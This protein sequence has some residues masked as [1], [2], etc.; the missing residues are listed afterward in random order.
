MMEPK[1]E[2][3]QHP[4]IRGLYNMLPVGWMMTPVEQEQWLEAARVNLALVYAETAEPRREDGAHTLPSKEQ[5][6]SGQSNQAHD[7]T[8]GEPLRT[9]VAKATDQS[10]DDAQ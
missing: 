5:G 8:S 2:A 4:L 1:I 3:L 9:A 7:V 6:G 10:G